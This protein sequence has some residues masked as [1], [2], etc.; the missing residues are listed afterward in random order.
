MSCPETK[1]DVYGVG[2]SANGRGNGV[3]LRDTPADVSVQL[4]PP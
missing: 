4:I 2:H 1:K 3:P